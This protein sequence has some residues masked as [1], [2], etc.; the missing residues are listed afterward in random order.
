MNA[1]TGNSGMSAGDGPS[2]DRRP[3]RAFLQRFASGIAL[4]VMCGVLAMLSRSFL[5]LG[6]FTNI[7]MQQA[8]IAILAI[9][10]TVVII[11]GGIDLSIGSVMALSGVVAALAMASGVNMWLS[12]AFG[13][14]TG[15]FC[16]FLNGLITSKGK[17]P[18]FITTLGMMGIARGATM[19]LTGGGAVSGLPTEFRFLGERIAGGIPTPVL[20]VVVVAVAVHV[21]LR[22]ARLGRYVYAIGGNKE[23]ARLSG[24]NVDWYTTLAFSL[25]GLLAGIAGVMLASRLVS[26]QPT[27]GE[28]YELHAIAAAVIGGASLMGGEGTIAGTLVGAAIMAV[29]RNGCNLLDVDA[30]WQKIAIG[31]VIIAAVFYDQFRRRR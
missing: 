29:L 30:F 5:T 8:D 20:V 16:G 14:T 23:S 9:G 25:C 27:A 11:C 12:I 4:I 24:I 21:M 13:I 17:I 7:G 15:L 6:N 28:G 31:A 1:E 26:G 2:R 19:I 18:P 10:Q 3:V 22:Y